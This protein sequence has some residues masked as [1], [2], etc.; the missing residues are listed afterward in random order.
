MIDEPG[1]DDDEP[2]SFHF[3]ANAPLE[4][5]PFYEA[6]GRLA[7]EWAE[8]EYYM[9][10]AIWSLANVSRHAGTC[11]T[12]QLIGPGPRF[13]CLVAL[14]HVREVSEELIN[15][16]NSLASE[17]ESLGR[18]RNRYLHDPLVLDTTDRKVYRIETTADRKLRHDF[19]SIDLE[20]VKKLTYQILKVAARFDDLYDR[21]VAETPPW[22]RKQYERSKGIHR[23]HTRSTDHPSKP[24][25]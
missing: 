17:A 23:D 2:V 12:S 10:D 6:V 18:Q 19:V 1:D 9:N 16:M 13:R 11:L 8:F 21:V 3:T 25:A 24:D 4:F 7:L 15:A 5:Q 22:P 14:L 20:A